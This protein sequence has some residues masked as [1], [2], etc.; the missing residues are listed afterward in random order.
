M[1]DP[2]YLTFV[3]LFEPKA[4]SET[5][6]QRTASA[7]AAPVTARLIGRIAGQLGVVPMSV[8]ATQ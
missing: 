7:N 4:S 2:H 6:G 8:V 5:G 1:D 3:L